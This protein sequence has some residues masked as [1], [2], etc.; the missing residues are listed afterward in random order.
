MYINTDTSSPMKCLY[1]TC[2]AMS[3]YICWPRGGGGGG[4]TSKWGVRPEP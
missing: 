4:G 2:I 3:D 1:R